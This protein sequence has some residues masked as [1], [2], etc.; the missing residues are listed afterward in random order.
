MTDLGRVAADDDLLRVVAAG[1]GRRWASIGAFIVLA[2]VLLALVVPFLPLQ[3]VTQQHSDAVLQG[4]SSAHWLGTDNLGR[5][6]FARTLWGGRPSIGLAL[7][8]V[9]LAA[10][11][12]FVIGT[13]AAL[14]G[15]WVDT[16]LMRI[17]DVLLALPS[18]LVLLLVASFVGRD[19]AVLIATLAVMYAP[20]V[21][22]LVRTV[23]LNVLTRDFVV[24][25]RLR[26][27][28]RWELVSSEVLPN[29]RGMVL[30][31]V[32]MQFTWI[33]LAFSSLSVL[34]LGASPPTPEWGLMIAESRSY[35]SITAWPVVAP[36]VMLATLVLGVNSLVDR[37]GVDGGA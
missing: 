7:A 5:D 26:G 23:S 9:V 29:I 12:G 15:G 3:D 10:L 32:A 34:G 35:M 36:V 13:F 37:N 2:H 6:V 24:A 22:R 14:A 19:T 16:V 30:T 8:S 18:L 27:A 33:L 31:E 17:N 21:A 1:R 11:L 25:A 28:S 20:P 4:P